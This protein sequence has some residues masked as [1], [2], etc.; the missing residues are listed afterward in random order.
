MFWRVGWPLLRAEGFFCNLDILYGGLGIGKLQFFLS[1]KKFN[2]FPAVIFFHFWSLK[3]WIRI[4]SGSGSGSGWNEC[5]SATLIGSN[6][7]SRHLNNLPANQICGRSLSVWGPPSPPRFLFAGSEFG[8]IHIVKLL[9]NMLSNRTQ[10][11]HPL[12]ATRCLYILYCTLRGGKR[13]GEGGKPER[14]LE[15]Q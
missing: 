15:G 10:H 4:A 14:R 1:K 2:F 3:P 8:Q 13:G 7:K 11:P 9:Q 6:E 12:P 5:G